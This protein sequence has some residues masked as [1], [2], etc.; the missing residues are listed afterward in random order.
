[1][2]KSDRMKV[3]SIAVLAMLVGLVQ[4]KHFLIETETKGKI[5]IFS[6]FM[7]SFLQKI[8]ETMKAM[9]VTMQIQS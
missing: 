5:W 3:A 6:Y 9:V 4:L 1:M 7:F 8:M 2:I